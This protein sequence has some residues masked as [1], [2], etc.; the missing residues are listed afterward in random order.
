MLP[1]NHA[2]P[3]AP[4]VG[5]VPD[6]AP[7]KRSAAVDALRGIAIVALVFVAV[8]G[9]GSASPL[10]LR[11]VLWNGLHVADF[12]FPCFLVAAGAALGLTKKHAAV[13]TAAW[14]SIR[15]FAI[16]VVLVAVETAEIG[17][18]SGPLQLLAVAWF[19]GALAM[20]LDPTKRLV[21]A[22]ALLT[23]SVLVHLG[24]WT[25]TGADRWVDTPIFGERSDLGLLCMLWSS[26]AVILASVVA[27]QIRPMVV[28]AR[29]R[30][31]L[32]HAAVLGSIGGLAAIAGV[33]VVMRLW[34][35]S[36]V[37]I[38][39]AGC[40]ALWAV[41][42]LVLRE[43]HRWAI[44][45]LAVGRN[46]LVI[47]VVMSL[48]G[49]LVPADWTDAFVDGIGSGIGVTGASLAYSAVLTTLLVVVAE[50]MRRRSIV[51]RI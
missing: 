26:V 44:P 8:P 25:A 23:A 20:R 40:F 13:T 19:L 6:V 32:F 30:T 24:G 50:A 18:E 34:T 46:A 42:E 14:R 38:T 31:L 3:G 35:P 22:G 29:V 41:L 9:R 51:V 12:V 36:Y 45:L 15:L 5:G 7:S 27:E 2:V 4:S 10:Q 43:P 21:L 28:A 16:G 49:S 37:L 33:P 17:I 48:I 11:N 1:G 39:V 47:Y